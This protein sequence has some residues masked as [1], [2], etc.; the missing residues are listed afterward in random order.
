M[1]STPLA[2]F[3]R[4]S[5]ARI[6][7]QDIGVPDDGRQRRV[8]GLRREEVAQLANLS[9]DYLTRLEQGRVTSASPAILDALADALGLDPAGREYLHSIAEPGRRAPSRTETVEPATYRLLDNLYEIPALV[10]GPRLD[11]LAWNRLAAA[12]FV[13]Y[14]AVPEEDR[15]LIRLTFLDPAYRRLYDDWPRAARECVA[16]LRMEARNFPDDK[17][18]AELVGELAAEDPDFRTWWNS[19]QVAGS[20]LRRKSYRHPLVGPLTLDAQQLDVNGRSDQHLV[21]YTAEPDSPSHDA[22]HLLAQWANSPL[23]A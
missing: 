17:R 8:P 20:T 2:Q 22:L 7:P 21:V 23:A 15:N 19:H 13:D 14:D 18:L 5:R 6:R 11:I 3:L 16:Y 10:F 1:S 9:V 12:L 4:A